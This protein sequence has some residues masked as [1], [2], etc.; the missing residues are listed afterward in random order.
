MS[1]RVRARGD[2]AHERL[3]RERHQRVD[4]VEVARVERP[5]VRLADR[6]ARRV[7]L[8]ERL[9]EPDEVLEV[10]HRSRCAARSPRARTGSRRPPRRP[11]ARRRCGRSARGCAPGCRTRAAPSRPARARSPGRASRSGR[12]PAGPPCGRARAPRRSRNSIPSSETIRR[13]PLSSVSIG[14]LGQ[15]L[16]ARHLV[17]QHGLSSISRSRAV[18]RP[19]SP[20]SRTS[21][22]RPRIAAARSACARSSGRRPLREPDDA[23]VVAEVVVA[24]LGVAVEAEAAP[25]RRGRSCGRGSRSGST[26][27]A[28]RPAR[29]RRPRSSG[30]PSSRAQPVERAARAAVGVRDDDVVAVRPPRR[31]RRG[32]AR[33]GCAAPAAP[34]ARRASQP[35][36]ARSPRR[37]ARARRRRRRPASCRETRAGR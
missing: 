28:R 5:V 11:C 31:P 23:R 30:R 25:R 37:A 18:S 36:R 21:S 9:R 24:Q 7:E 12:R 20:V 4:H 32:S 27:P 14:L 19:R 3:V 26:C 6:P 22:G 29:R 33:A 8:R 1:A 17:D 13:Q 16:V 35:R 10:V 2:R 15:D 34:G